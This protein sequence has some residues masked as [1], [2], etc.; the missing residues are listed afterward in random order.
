MAQE[1]KYTVFETR[2]GYFGLLGSEKGLSRTFLP[3]TSRRQAEEALL[4]APDT[5]E[6]DPGAFAALQERVKSYFEGIYVD[7]SDVPIDLDRVT[8]FGRSIL[9]ACRKIEYAQTVSYSQL[10]ALAGRPKAIRAVGGALGS[11]PVPLIIPCHRVITST[12]QIGGFSAPG[13]KKLKKRMLLLE[14][15]NAI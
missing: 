4:K 3:V 13:G 9:T 8:E 2:W 5:P 15:K 11:N 1:K 7:F 6:F 12:G 14:Q 10:A